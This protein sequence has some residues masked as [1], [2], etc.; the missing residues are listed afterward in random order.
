[1]SFNGRL[2]ASSL[3]A[4]SATLVLWLAPAVAQ[5]PQGMGQGMPRYNTGTEATLEGTV[6]EVKAVTSMRGMEGT[7]LM[8]KTESE[9][10]EV[11]LGPSAFL[12]EKNVELVKGDGVHVVGSRVKIAGA[13][14]LLAREIRKGEAT[15]TLRDESGRPLWRMGMRP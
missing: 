13:D 14:A 1:M 8:L 15:W 5:N 4:V 10:I 12:K 7:H 3:V 6:E 9:T 2:A 11:H